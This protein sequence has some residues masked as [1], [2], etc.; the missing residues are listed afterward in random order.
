MT[1]VEIT[2][3]SADFLV[4]RITSSTLGH[5]DHVTQFPRVNRNGRFRNHNI[6]NTLLQTQHIIYKQIN[7][8]PVFCCC[9][10]NN[11]QRVFLMKL[12]TSL[13]G[14]RCLIFE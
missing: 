2:V 1:G 11:P 10:N 6:S 8:S 14:A 9:S 7:T 3:V 5:G 13:L 4:W 12:F